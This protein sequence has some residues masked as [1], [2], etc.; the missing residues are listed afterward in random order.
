MTTVAR[1][2]QAKKLRIEMLLF[3]L[4]SE[5]R[6]AIHEQV[7]TTCCISFRSA[8]PINS[9]DPTD[10]PSLQRSQCT[11]TVPEPVADHSRRPRCT[12][13]AAARGGRRAALRLSTGVYSRPPEYTSST[14]RP[15]GAA[16]CSRTAW[17]TRVASV[18]TC[19]PLIGAGYSVRQSVL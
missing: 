16:A 13:A 19:S 10:I 1:P 14:A 15:S 4:Q 5:E 3:V 12:G 17:V 2:I 8:G 7:L 6:K 11:V 18:R 9:P